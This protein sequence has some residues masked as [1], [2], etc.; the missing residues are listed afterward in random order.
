MIL[1]ISLHG[2]C[3][4]GGVCTRADWHLSGRVRYTNRKQ[5]V[6]PSPDKWVLEGKTFAQ[7]SLFW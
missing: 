7:L 1:L 6:L 4:G 5:V 3:V 2:G